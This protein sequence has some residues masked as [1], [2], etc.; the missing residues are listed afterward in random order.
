[1]VVVIRSRDGSD[2]MPPFHVKDHDA[3]NVPLP[4][5][6]LTLVA[7]WLRECPAGSPFLLLTPDR[8]ATVL[9]R[10]QNCQ[11]KARPW[12]N[13]YMVNNVIRDMRSHAKRA[14]IELDGALTV[15]ALRKSCGQNWANNLPMNVVKEFM[16]HADIATTAEFYTTVSKD[17][18]THARWII[19]KITVGGADETDARMTPEPKISPN[20]RVG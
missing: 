15:H 19:E 6:A 2:D 16:G 11:V 18:A 20:R 1:M 5:H 7:K 3:R 12:L 4:E 17:H 8:Y 9:K 14:G 10:W 13:E